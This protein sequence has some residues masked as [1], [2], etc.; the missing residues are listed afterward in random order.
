MAMDDGQSALTPAAGAR[1]SARYEQPNGVQRLGIV[2]A[3]RAEACRKRDERQRVVGCVRE[4][5]VARAG[6]NKGGMFHASAA[7]SWRME[8]RGP[9]QIDMADDRNDE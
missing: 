6:R 8:R 5:E 7:S 3:A 9:C 4:L 1:I 2:H